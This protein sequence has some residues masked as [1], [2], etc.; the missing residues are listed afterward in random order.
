MT[1]KGSD[2][3]PVCGQPVAKLSF[4]SP[5]RTGLAVPGCE[6]QDLQFSDMIPVPSESQSYCDTCKTGV[7]CKRGRTRKVGCPN[8]VLGRD[9]QL[10]HLNDIDIAEDER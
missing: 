6:M 4:L 10:G 9:T 5:R 8:R 2:K 7:I 3:L 1:V